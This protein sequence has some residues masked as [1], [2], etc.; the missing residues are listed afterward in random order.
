MENEKPKPSLDLLCEKRGV[1][2]CLAKNR[3]SKESTT[4]KLPTSGVGSTAWYTRSH[5]ACTHVPRHS[6]TDPPGT[7]TFTHGTY[8]HTE[9]CG[10]HIFTHS[11]HSYMEHTWH[12]Y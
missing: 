7:H 3:K 8:I 5:M 4:W 1:E 2:L 10:I 6:F 11:M 9:T 12:T